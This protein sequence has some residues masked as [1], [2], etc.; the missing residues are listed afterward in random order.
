MIL[1]EPFTIFTHQKGFEFLSNMRPYSIVAFGKKFR[2]SENLYQFSK[3]PDELHK[4][5]VDRFTKMHPFVARKITRKL[6]V[7]EDWEEIK[8]QVMFEVL[9][10]KFY[11]HPYLIKQLLDI[12]GP[13]AEFNTWKDTY[14]GYDINLKK[15]EN[16]LGKLFML[17][18]DSWKQGKS[19]KF[20]DY[21]RYITLTIEEMFND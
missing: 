12:E 21:N 1:Q 6:P 5:Y 13:L 8:L 4:E 16:H 11:Q 10:L 18:R 20:S 3:L 7:R 2:A 17:L 19:P 15:G 14:W 9:K